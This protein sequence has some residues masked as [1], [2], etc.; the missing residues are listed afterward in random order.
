MR[1]PAPTPSTTNRPDAAT[2]DDPYVELAIQDSPSNPPAAYL[3]KAPPDIMNAPVRFRIG[4]NFTYPPLTLGRK[5][6]EAVDNVVFVAGGVGVNPIMSMVSAMDL[7][8]A[9]KLGGMPKKVTILY[10]S[11]KTIDGAGQAEEV[12]FEHR[13]RA[14]AKKW[15]GKTKDAD[16]QYRFFETGSK[17]NATSNQEDTNTDNC[18]YLRRRMT[19][20]DLFDALGPEDKRANTLAYVCGLPDMTDG[21]VDVLKTAPGMDERRVLCEKWW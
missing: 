15:V 8:G 16:L 11:K 20:Q 4:G 21:F 12:L 2:F 17:S 5:E 3:W 13:L 18:Q 10:S 19:H 7:Q 6:F 9:G 1:L 14:I